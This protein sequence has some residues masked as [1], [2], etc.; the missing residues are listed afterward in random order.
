MKVEIL[1]ASLE[2][3][4]LIQRMME[5]YLYDFSAFDH[6]DLDAHGCFG[7][8]YLDHYWVEEGRHPFL[9]R[10][11]GKLAGFV[12]VNQQ[13]R[14]PGNEWSVAEFFILRKYRRRGIGKRVAQFIFDQFRGKWEVAEI[15]SNSDA[16][17]FWKAAIGEYTGG[18]YEEVVLEDER[19]KGPVQFFDN[20]IGYT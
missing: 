8:P 20:T 17:S 15:D 2:D 11:D 19:W 5:L 16:R 14:L 12:L 6:S 9:V 13:T 3:K 10:V 7:Y 4:P 1:A 18:T